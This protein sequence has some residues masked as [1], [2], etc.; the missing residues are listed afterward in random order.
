M[1]KLRLLKVVVQPTFVV[2]DGENLN[3]IVAESIMS[4]YPKTIA[5]EELAVD[6]LDIMR[7]NNITQLLVTENNT[8][9]G[10]IHIHDIIKEGII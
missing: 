8:Y 4:I 3:E 6:A 2:D 7:K 1:K 10:I 9:S 5:T